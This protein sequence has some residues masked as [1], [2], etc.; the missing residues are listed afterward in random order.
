[1][2]SLE[3]LAHCYNNE[4]SWD[5]ICRACLRTVAT[6]ATEDSLNCCEAAHTCDPLDLYYVDKPLDNGSAPSTLPP[7][8]D[9]TSRVLSGAILPARHSGFASA[10]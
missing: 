4:R 1:M 10:N 5:S 7:D 3:N 6:V 2:V 8:G 9:L